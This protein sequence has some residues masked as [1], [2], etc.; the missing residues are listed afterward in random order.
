MGFS[1]SAETKSQVYVDLTG[2]LSGASEAATTARSALSVEMD[3]RVN[4]DQP[5]SWQDVV[6][7]GVG[8]ARAVFGEDPKKNPRPWVR[9]GEAE[10]SVL[11]RE[12]SRANGRKLSAVTAEQWHDANVDVRRSKRRRLS[13]LKDREVRWWDQKAQAAQAKADQ[14]DAF[15]LF[16][17]FRELGA[18]IPSGEVAPKDAQAERDAWAVHFRLIGE[19]PGRVAEKVWDNVPSY[20]PMDVVWGNPPAPNELHAALR[21]MSLGKAAGEDEVTA[22]LLKFGSM[23]SPQGLRNKAEMP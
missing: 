20:P 14:G 15:G 23:R 18:N 19:G 4:E 10:L 1:G 16:A 11:D 9:G 2:R 12:V 5:S 17:T 8:V 6:E 7:L 3:R 21:Q 13:W 22:E